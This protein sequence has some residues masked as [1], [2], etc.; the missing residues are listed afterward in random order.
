MKTQNPIVRVVFCMAFAVVLIGCASVEPKPFLSNDIRQRLGTVAIRPTSDLPQVAIAGTPIGKPASA[1]LGA[2]AGAGMAGFV[3]AIQSLGCI[4]APP[5]C[6]PSM[7][8]YLALGAVVGAS[9]AGSYAEAKTPYSDAKQAAESATPL[10][11]QQV[12]AT[13]ITKVAGRIDSVTVA[14]SPEDAEIVIEVGVDNVEIDKFGYLSISGR[15]QISE[16]EP[17][18]TLRTYPFQFT[19]LESHTFKEWSADNGREFV[20]AILRGLIP[21]GQ[22][23]GEELFLLERFPIRIKPKGWNPSTKTLSW[24]SIDEQ[25]TTTQKPF[26][27]ELWV[28]PATEKHSCLDWVAR[29]QGSPQLNLEPPCLLDASVTPI[30]T[31]IVQGS[32]HQHN[33]TTELDDCADY[34]WSIRA[35]D[36]PQAKRVADWATWSSLRTPCI[37]E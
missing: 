26:D 9:F 5:S 35:V 16:S 8:P 32:L 13:E 36:G 31:A 6:I 23:V 10:S 3:W 15:A 14:S 28:V 4:F 20:E 21:I 34:R 2:T 37:R 25:P 22:R 18:K 30:Y 11:A 1:A 33:I 7:A 12:L 19:F 29:D 27:F 24:S 17:L